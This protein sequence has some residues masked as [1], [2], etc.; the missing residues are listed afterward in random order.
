MTTVSIKIDFPNDAQYTLS[1]GNLYRVIARGSQTNGRFS[2][3]VSIL[4]PGQGGPAHTHSNEQESFYITKGELTVFDGETEAKVPEGSF[5]FCPEGAIRGF[6][7]DSEQ[8]VEMLIFYTPSGIENMIEMDG[9]SV[10]A[11][12]DYQNHTKARKIACPALNKQFG[13]EE[14]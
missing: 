4:K 10:N 11:L 8:D 1:A 6:R 9:T 2:L 12:E 13:I 5:I 3:L 7:N 14:K